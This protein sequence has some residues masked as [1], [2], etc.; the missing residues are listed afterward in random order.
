[1]VNKWKKHIRIL[2]AFMLGIAAVHCIPGERVIKYQEDSEPGR[3]C[4]P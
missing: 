2:A 4:E 3:R 1:M